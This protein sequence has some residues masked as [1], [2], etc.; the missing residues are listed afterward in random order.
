MSN[1]IYNYIYLPNHPKA[2][3]NGCVYEHIIVAEQ[4]IGRYLTEEEVVHHIDENKKNNS[5]ENLI[6]FATNIDHS[7]FHKLNLNISELSFSDGHYFVEI[8]EEIIRNI[9]HKHLFSIEQFKQDFPEYIYLLNKCAVCGKECF[10]KYCS[11]E[12]VHIS[13][14]KFNPTKDELLNDII[15]MSMIQVG[16]KYGVSDNAIRK[17]CKKLGLPFYTKDI[18]KLIIK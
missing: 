6:V 16:K 10:N 11:S 14:S 9:I 17:R 18:K 4:K 3:Q 1:N 13:Q 15:N 8:T 7:R 5:P 2:H 12:C